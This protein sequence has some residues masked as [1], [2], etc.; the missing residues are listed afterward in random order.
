MALNQVKFTRTPTKFSMHPFYDDIFTRLSSKCPT[1]PLCIPSIFSDYSAYENTFKPLLIEETVSQ[2]QSSLNKNG[3]SFPATFINSRPMKISTLISI[4]VKYV[5]HTVMDWAK[6][7][8]VQVK[9]SKDMIMGIVEN[10]E[11]SNHLEIIL[12][13]SETLSKTLATCEEILIFPLTNIITSTREYIGLRSFTLLQRPLQLALLQPAVSS[14]GQFRKVRDALLPLVESSLASSSNLFITEDEGIL[15]HLLRSIEQL[16]LS[17]SDLRLFHNIHDILET[18]V[19]YHPQLDIQLVARR[20]QQQFTSIVRVDP[21]KIPASLPH[22][23]WKE[24]KLE[25]NFSQLSAI[26]SVITALTERKCA[27]QVFTLLQGPP[28]KCFLTF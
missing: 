13:H 3:N 23:F 7:D 19:R 18:I 21:R 24:L 22:R 28:G 12:Q 14:Q 11:E 20:V 6:H 25:Y 5:K 17:A 9:I 27:N 16:H 2:I 26:N 4:Q 15:N 8:V 10:C 1:F